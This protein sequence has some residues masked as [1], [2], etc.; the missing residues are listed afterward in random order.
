MKARWCHGCTRLNKL[1]LGGT[2]QVERTPRGVA[3]GGSGRRIDIDGVCDVRQI[4]EKGVATAKEDEKIFILH[5]CVPTDEK[6][7]KRNQGQLRKMNGLYLNPMLM[8]RRGSYMMGAISNF[9]QLS[10]KADSTENLLGS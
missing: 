8:Y 2:L 6:A 10:P 5:T 1:G 7:E 3:N 9:L 4:V